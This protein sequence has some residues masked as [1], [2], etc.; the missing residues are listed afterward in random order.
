[1]SLTIHSLVDHRSPASLLSRPHQQPPHPT[2]CNI[3]HLPP[4][5]SPR[6]PHF[7]SILL[8]AP[9][10]EH[11]RSEVWLGERFDEFMNK[12]FEI[13]ILEL[14]DSE[15]RAICISLRPQSSYNAGFAEIESEM[16]LE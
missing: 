12:L 14:F 15:L 4:R 7:P 8:P 3:P 16:Y 9:P 2:L 5:P 6:V 1:M 11:Y 10:R 13:A